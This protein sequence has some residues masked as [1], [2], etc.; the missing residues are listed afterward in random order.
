MEG[1]DVPHN[2]GAITAG[3][4]GLVVVFGDLD[5]PHTSPMLF[6]GSFHVLALFA[7]SEDTDLTFRTSGDHSAAVGGEGQGSDSV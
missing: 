7:E 1:T 4:D 6:H 2:A 3:T 5:G